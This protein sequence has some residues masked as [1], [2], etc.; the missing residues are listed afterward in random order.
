MKPLII[1]G[2][3]DIAQLANY[4]FEND[5][6]YKVAAFTVDRAFVTEGFEGK[7]VIPFDELSDHLPPSQ[8][9]MFIAL[10]Y[11]NLNKVREAKY[12]AA[13]KAG[14]QLVSYVSTKC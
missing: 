1:F 12:L 5:S 8:Y 3:G 10:S 11:K 9:D 6:P 2:T 13:K 14:Y 7:D 4:Y